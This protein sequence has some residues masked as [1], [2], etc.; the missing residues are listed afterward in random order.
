MPA[1]VLF[2]PRLGAGQMRRQTRRVPARRQEEVSQDF[3]S[4][5]TPARRLLAGKEFSAGH[6]AAKLNDSLPC[7]VELSRVR[8]A[9]ADEEVWDGLADA[10]WVS[11][12]GK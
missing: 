12:R 10:L 7:L 6:V 4:S 11:A 3:V 9:W 5:S 2:V 8:P 1:T